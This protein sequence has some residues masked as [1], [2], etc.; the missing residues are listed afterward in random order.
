MLCHTSLGIYY[1]KIFDM[2]QHHGYSI[3]EMENMIPFERDL[4]YEMLVMYIQAKKD[5]AQHE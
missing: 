1:R 2:A 5:R 3:A 4:Y